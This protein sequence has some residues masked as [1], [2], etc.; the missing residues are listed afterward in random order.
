MTYIVLLL[1]YNIIMCYGLSVCNY[2]VCIVFNFRHHV[3]YVDHL[4]CVCVKI[5]GVCVRCHQ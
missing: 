3:K 1:V 5:Q 4:T 2:V